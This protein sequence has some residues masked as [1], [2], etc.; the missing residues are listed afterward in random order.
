[1]SVGTRGRQMDEMLEILPRFLGRRLPEFHGEFYDFARTA[2]FPVPQKK[3]NVLIGGSSGAALRRAARFDGF[4][5]M[6]PAPAVELASHVRAER[7]AGGHTGPYTVMVVR[8]LF[9]DAHVDLAE[10]ASLEQQGVTAV[11]LNAWPYFDQDYASIDSK[12]SALER[13]AQ[14]LRPVG[15]KPTRGT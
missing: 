3:I 9:G 7:A 2:M 11:L 14:E 4:L 15:S 10:V 12:L 13:A 8:S 5:P 6:D 1:M